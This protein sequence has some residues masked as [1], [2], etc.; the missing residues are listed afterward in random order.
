M[1]IDV[2]ACDGW[3]RLGLCAAVC[4]FGGQSGGAV[5]T[6]MGASVSTTDCDFTNNKAV[7]GRWGEGREGRER[8]SAGGTMGHV[9]GA[10]QHIGRLR[11]RM[12]EEGL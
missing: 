2:W 5:S 9:P 12:K 3:C 7:G 11:G 10:R 1:R 4:R 6:D 8:D